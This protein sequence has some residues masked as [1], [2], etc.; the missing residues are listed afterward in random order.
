MKEELEK[1][2]SKLNKFLSGSEKLLRIIDSL[3]KSL[4]AKRFSEEMEKFN[5]YLKGANV[6]ISK[7][8]EEFREFKKSWTKV[9]IAFNEMVDSLANFASK[10]LLLAKGFLSFDTNL[11]TIG[12]TISSLVNRFTFFGK[13]T[14]FVAGAI[15]SVEDYIRALRTI[16]RST[17]LF[18][19][20]LEDLLLTAQRAGMTLETYSQYLEKFSGAINK[21]GLDATM[22]MVSSLRINAKELFLMGLTVREINEYFGMFLDQ[23]RYFDGLRNRNER[24][25]QAMFREQMKI[26]YEITKAT[27]RTLDSVFRS[28]SE[29]F[30]DPKSMAILQTLPE[31]IRME[32]VKFIE[33]FP[34]LS[35]MFLTA[36]Q[37]G[38]IEFSED[39]RKFAT[40]FL[41]Q[42]SMISRGLI[43]GAI[44]AKQ[45]YEIISDAVNDITEDQKRLFA[46]QGEN[47]YEAVS[48][49]ISEVNRINK[50]FENAFSEKRID[51]ISEGLLKLQSFFVDFSSTVRTKLLMG[52][53]GGEKTSEE[54]EKVFEN[55]KQRTSSIADNILKIIDNFATLLAGRDE[56]GKTTLEK[57]VVAVDNFIGAISKFVEF[58]TS[59]V[60][61]NKEL[62]VPGVLLL[63]K[64]FRNFFRNLGS[65]LID[66]PNLIQQ[67]FRILTTPIRSLLSG[68]K[69]ADLFDESVSKKIIEESAEKKSASG[70]DDEERLGKTTPKRRRLVDFLRKGFKFTLGGIAASVIGETIL[71]N[72]ISEGQAKEAIESSLTGAGIGSAIGGLAGSLFPG[73]GTM[74]G[75]LLG[76]SLGAIIGGSTSSL[77]KEI[78]QKFQKNLEDVNKSIQDLQLPP[79]ASLEKTNEELIN[80]R[81]GIHNIEKQFAELNRRVTENNVISG[82]ILKE[83]RT[84]NEKISD[85]VIGTFLEN[86]S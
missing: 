39:Y 57:L 73:I 21:L 59:L 56:T 32:F 71:D 31:N 16:S 55:L 48:T 77:A 69:L 78:E 68:R 58:L 75:T 4:R 79:A 50:N 76:G 80:I 5:R 7:S 62:L 83:N 24:E 60:G 23:Q 36:V 43:T 52:L 25:L 37:K 70:A 12:E 34:S 30:R 22:R 45:A 15:A 14:A 66:L 82:A 65:L 53:L 17:V 6:L 81:K 41:P 28:I 47:V 11:R 2:I 61:E 85:I 8:A 10:T 74:L 9:K 20:G 38:S 26:T 51:N 19:D 49:L 35:N 18:N 13:I 54:L 67:G 63:S 84:S 40:S 1:A 27:G 64:S 86:V 33:L 46:L 29:R 3:E 42:L 44:T 72:L